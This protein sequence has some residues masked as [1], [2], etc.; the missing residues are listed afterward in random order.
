MEQVCYKQE[1]NGGSGMTGTYEHSID[2]AGRL[3]VPSKL[4]DKL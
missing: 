3:I 2:N 1:G 4:R